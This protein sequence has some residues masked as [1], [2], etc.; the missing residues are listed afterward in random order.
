M[1]V[2]VE[3]AAAE[4]ASAATAPAVPAAA[5]ATAPAAAAAPSDTK[6]MDTTGDGSDANK[7]K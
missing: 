1:K 6:A 7:A 4:V 2:E 3:G 5:A